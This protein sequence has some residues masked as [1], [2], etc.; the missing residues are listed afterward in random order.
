MR[1]ILFV[2]L[3]GGLGDL[4]IALPAI[5]A[6]ALSHPRAQV[7]VLTFAPGAEL[8]EA[9]PLVQRVTASSAAMAG[10]GMP[11]RR[12]WPGALRPS[13]SDTTYDGSTCCSGGGHALVTNLAGRRRPT[14]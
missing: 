8:V 2:E 6:L 1:R 11:W 7:A 12:S 14:S 9:D 5:H 13:S 3:L 4:V 10:R